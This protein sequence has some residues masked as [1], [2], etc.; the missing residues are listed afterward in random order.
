[1]VSS[2]VPTSTQSPWH[3]LSPLWSPHSSHLSLTSNSPPSLPRPGCSGLPTSAQ[4]S[5]Y[6]PPTSTQLCHRPPTFSH[7]SYLF[8]SY[9]VKEADNWLVSMTNLFEAP[10]MLVVSVWVRG[11]APMLFTRLRYSEPSQERERR[12]WP[13][14]RENGGQWVG[15][16]GQPPTHRTALWAKTLG[17]AVI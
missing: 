1:M 7:Y 6:H 16:S 4:S 12:V 2:C 3:C 5:M 14:Q 11:R 10:V 17:Q 9:V 15:C 8:N 13:E